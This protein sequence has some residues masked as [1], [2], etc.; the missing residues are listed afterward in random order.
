MKKNLKLITW[1]TAIAVGLS[2]TG[3]LNAKE[4]GNKGG[5]N[6]GSQVI[7]TH[8]QP[9]YDDFGNRYKP[10]V[11]R[12][13][14]GKHYA[15][16]KT[17]RIDKKIRKLKRKKAKKMRRMRRISNRYDNQYDRRY[18]QRYEPRYDTRRAPVYAPVYDRP[19]I[20]IPVPFLR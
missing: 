11:V 7:I 15:Y 12:G 16:G 17:P 8:Q 2:L 20:V 14:R 4:R 9:I 3:P 10:L 18:D 1:I 6:K 19:V 13:D 5:K